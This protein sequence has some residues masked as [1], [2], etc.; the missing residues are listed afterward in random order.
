MELPTLRDGRLVL[1]P[2]SDADLDA[3]VALLDVPGVRE[4]WAPSQDRHDDLRCE[5]NAFAI[6]V[7]DELAGWLGFAE[8]LDPDYLHASMDILLAPHFQGAGLGPAALRLLAR[9]FIDERGHHRI[10]IDPNCRNARAIGAYES[11]GFRR[12]GVL[13]RYE[14]GHDGEWEDGLLMDLLAEELR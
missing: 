13:R 10:T 2:P 1:R 12:V 3:L 7:D 11:I 5:G 4:W 6:E 9:W 14:R 8:E